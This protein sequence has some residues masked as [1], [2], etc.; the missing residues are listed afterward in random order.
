MLKMIKKEEETRRSVQERK[1]KKK[2]REGI[3]RGIARSGRG[4]TSIP[5]MSMDTLMDTLMDNGLRHSQR[6]DL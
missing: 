5:G 3:R 6:K 4:I 1:K 2:T